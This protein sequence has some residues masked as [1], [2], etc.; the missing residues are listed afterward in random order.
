M[1]EKWKEIRTSLMEQIT[2]HGANQWTEE[3]LAALFPAEIDES[4]EDEVLTRINTGTQQLLANKEKI[5]GEKKALQKK[6]ADT[7]SINIEEYDA[8]IE[9]LSAANEELNTKLQQQQKTYETSSATIQKELKKTSEF[10]SVEKE[11]VNGLLKRQALSEGLG[12]LT[13]NPELL[14]ALKVYLGQKISL[15]EDPSTPEG[16]KAVCEIPDENGKPVQ[17][18]FDKYLKDVWAP[19]EGKAYIL[20]SANGGAGGGNSG[21]AGGHNQGTDTESPFGDLKF[22]DE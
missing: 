17:M 11:R 13:I 3:Q 8:K 15:V 19:A 21:A 9:H 1:M 16:R 22:N 5:L 18:P 4:L 6:L 14:P 2:Q 10:A 20:N 7:T 12:T